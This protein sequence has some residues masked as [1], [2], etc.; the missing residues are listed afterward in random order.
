MWRT[1]AYR[2]ED[3]GP[4]AEFLV[5]LGDESFSSRLR[6]K[7]SA[8]YRWKYGNGPGE[9]DRV[10]LAIG[11]DGLI[12]VVA[13]LPRRIKLG[14]QVL[15]AFEFGDLL[16]GPGYRRQGVFSTLGREAC[17]ASAAM[18]ALSYVKP[19]ADAAPALLK[20]LGFRPLLEL[21]TL[22]RPIRVSR[23]LAQRF[24]R[25]PFGA[26]GR[27]LDKLF[28]VRASSGPPFLTREAI[29]GEEFDGLWEAVAGDYPAIVVRDRTYLEWRYR[30]NPTDYTV[31]AARDG[32]GRLRGY[33]VG[34]VVQ[35]GA[36]RIGYLVDILARREDRATQ[37]AL[38]RGIL[39]SCSDEGAQTV[40]TWIAK[41]SASVQS[42]LRSALR[43]VGFFHRGSDWVLWR[44]SLDDLPSDQRA[45]YLTMADF[46]G[47]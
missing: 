47:I 43:S 22:A 42:T 35:W 19:N 3:L 1:R 4:L 16:T 7:V 9:S 25:W 21:E 27:P 10:R 40:H 39:R 20:H 14:G 32:S 30:Q 41:E 31:L 45:W 17:E 24:G 46:D 38:A 33:A 18:G 11:V 15:T 29:F 37:V 26:W 8:Y 13:M 28:A 12:G 5:P 23:I 36:R 34:L 44:P 2:V 6:G